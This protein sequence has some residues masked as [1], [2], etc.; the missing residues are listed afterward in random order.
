MSIIGCTEFEK[1]IVRV[2]A[3]DEMIDS[4]IVVGNTGYSELVSDLEL[5]GL[6]PLI[7]LPESIP[8]GIKESKAFNVLVTLQDARVYSSPQHMKKEAYE[9]IKFYGLVSNGVLM[10]YDSCEGL[11]ENTLRDFR[12]SDFLLEFI[13]SDK[14][15]SIEDK[16]DTCFLGKNEKN[17][18]PSELVEEYKVCYKRL[19]DMILSPRENQGSFPGCP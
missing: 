9:K 3:D 7:F 14:G 12:N 10:F 15:R 19:K 16:V 13:H 8:K 11:F 4:L 2:L 6:E 5:M 1:E 17:A 18:H